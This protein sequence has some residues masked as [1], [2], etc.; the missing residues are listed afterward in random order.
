MAFHVLVAF[1]SRSMTQAIV[2]QQTVLFSCGV[3]LATII[4]RLSYRLQR[5]EFL[6]RHR[7]QQA[8][9]RLARFER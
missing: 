3:V 7:L 5:A 1:T 4:A 2:E 6:S 8:N 9:Q